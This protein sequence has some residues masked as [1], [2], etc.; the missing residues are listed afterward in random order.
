MRR[1][2][3]QGHFPCASG[4]FQIGE[5][6]FSGKPQEGGELGDSKMQPGIALRSMGMTQSH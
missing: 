5:S 2:R 6:V 4:Q 1:A 3:C